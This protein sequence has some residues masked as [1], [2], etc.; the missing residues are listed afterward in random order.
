MLGKVLFKKGGVH[1]HT[2]TY[3]YLL[4]PTY[5]ALPD[6]KEYCKPYTKYNGKYLRVILTVNVILSA[7]H[8]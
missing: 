7:L 3:M 6:K 8:V 5:T 4:V 2:Y 1:T